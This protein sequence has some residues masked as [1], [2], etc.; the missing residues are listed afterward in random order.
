MFKSIAE[1]QPGDIIIEGGNRTTV[2]KVESC[3]S[4]KGTKT[5]IN[6]KDCWESFSEVRVQDNTS[7]DQADDYDL[8]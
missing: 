5:H 6:E 4:S 8:A 7:R 3:P 1:V 2:R